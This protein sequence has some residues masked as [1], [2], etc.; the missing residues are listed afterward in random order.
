MEYKPH[1]TL[2]INFTQRIHIYKDAEKH[3]IVTSVTLIFSNIRLNLTHANLIIRKLYSVIYI[4]MK[5]DRCNTLKLGLLS[6]HTIKTS[7]FPIQIR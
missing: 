7:A 2:S 5:R 1:E 4:M 6:T 3:Q